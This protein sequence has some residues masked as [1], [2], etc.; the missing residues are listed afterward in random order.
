MQ[1]A[2]TVRGPG[3]QRRRSGVVG[4]GR[5]LAG[6]VKQKGVAERDDIRAAATSLPAI[7]SS[8]DGAAQSRRSAY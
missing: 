4:F 3:W 7:T 5:C 8:P 2:R 1:C 6:R